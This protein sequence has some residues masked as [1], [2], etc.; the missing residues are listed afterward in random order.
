MYV[1]LQSSC[2]ETQFLVDRVASST[3][4]YFSTAKQ[5]KAQARKRSKDFEAE[6]FLHPSLVPSSEF[7]LT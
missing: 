7:T 5:A 4:G 6:N 3:P 2:N 1:H